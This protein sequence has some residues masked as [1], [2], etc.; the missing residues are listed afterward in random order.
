MTA[1]RVARLIAEKHGERG[2][3][4]AQNRFL[5]WHFWTLIRPRD[6]KATV[7]RDFWRRVAFRA[8]VLVHGTRPETA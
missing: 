3:E 1:L 6:T 5:R 4:L 8:H 2:I 7:S